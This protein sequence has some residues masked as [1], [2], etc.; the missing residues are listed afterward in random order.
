MCGLSLAAIGVYASLANDVASRTR[1]LGVRIAL[2]ASTRRIALLVV[3][4][5]LRPAAIGAAAGLG[6]AFIVSGR[7]E[8]LLFGVSARDPLTFSA[9]AIGL[10]VVAVVASAVPARRAARA[11]PIVALRAE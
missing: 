3:R 1:E 2:G 5:A 11:D 7:L 6:P 9:A 4:D 8:G 10:C